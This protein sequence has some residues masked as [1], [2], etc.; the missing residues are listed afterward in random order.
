MCVRAR[1][2]APSADDDR[3]HSP[4]PLP[5]AKSG[6]DFKQRHSDLKSAKQFINLLSHQSVNK[7]SQ[8]MHQSFLSVGTNL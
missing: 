3:T 6:A 8:S 2:R 5:V 7:S 1:A 4:P